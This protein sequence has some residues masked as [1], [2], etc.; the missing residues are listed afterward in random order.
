GA[1]VAER[2]DEEVGGLRVEHLHLRARERA[3]RERELY[4]PLV[5]AV[6]RLEPRERRDLRA[7]GERREPA[8]ALCVV[9]RFADRGRGD[10]GREKGR[11]EERAP[12]LSK[13][14]DEIAPAEAGAAV[15]LGNRQAEPAELAHLLPEVAR[16]ALGRLHQ[17][18]DLGHR[19]M[20]VEELA[21][22]LTKQVLFFGEAEFHVSSPT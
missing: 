20:R 1:A 12:H 5:A 18:T 16:E 14:H 6:A 13:H 22:L 10:R 17:V 15:R 2:D 8:A 9:A 21:H 7:V 4:P 11:G 19:T 3:A